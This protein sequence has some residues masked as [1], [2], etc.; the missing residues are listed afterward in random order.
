MKEADKELWTIIPEKDA[1]DPK[2]KL[3]ES[4]RVVLQS[5]EDLVTKHGPEALQDHP[6]FWNDHEL[7]DDWAGHRSSSFSSLGRIIY[8]VEGDKKTVVILKITAEHDHGRKKK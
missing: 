5:W 4:E 8:R 2:V 3:N 1:F 6:G 7:Y